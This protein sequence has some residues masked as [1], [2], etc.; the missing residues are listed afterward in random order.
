MDTS[1]KLINLALQGG[2]AHGALSWGVLDRLLEDNRLN[3]DC[4]SATSAGSMNA[5]ILLSGLLEGGPQKARDML[6]EFWLKISEMGE[7]YNP[8][9]PNFMEEM[10]GVPIDGSMS[11]RFFDMVTRMLSPYEFNPMNFNPLRDLLSSMVDFEKIRASQSTRLFIAATNVKT[12]K[13]R[14]FTENEMTLEAIMASACLPFLFQAVKVGEDYY[15]DGGYMG[16]PALYPI[17]YNAKSQDIVVVHINPIVRQDV[18]KTAAEIN[19]RVN[20]VSFNSS[21][22]REMRAVAFVTKML[23]EGWVK[24]SHAKKMKRI[25]MHSIA[26]DELMQT[27][28]CAT[29][30]NPDWTFISYLFEQGRA[31]AE[32]WLKDNYKHLGKRSSIDLNTYL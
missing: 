14:I 29:K 22:M 2:G 20:E 8:I 27:L 30:L 6:K 3:F 1:K 13:I 28:S 24:A 19:S 4:V 15:W 25:H 16:N 17:I 18:P 21:L 26:A 10:M 7:L 11:F 32:S 12:G 31:L 23:D 5:I 9:K